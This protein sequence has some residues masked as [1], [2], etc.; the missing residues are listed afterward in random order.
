[1]S[2]STGGSQQALGWYQPG[3]SR[4]RAREPLPRS[5][6]RPGEHPLEILGFIGQVPL[7]GEVGRRDRRAEPGNLPANQVFEA[8]R[9]DRVVV[10]EVGLEGVERAGGKW[11]ADLESD[12]VRYDARRPQVA[13]HGIGRDGVVDARPGVPVQAFGSR[14]DAE[15]RSLV[16]VAR[17]AGGRLGL[18]E[19]H[20]ALVRADE[21]FPFV[22]DP[23][24]A[25]AGLAVGQR[26]H[27]AAE[28]AGGRSQRGL[29]GI[30]GQAPDEKQFA[31]HAAPGRSCA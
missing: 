8:A 11:Q 27:Q 3:Q 20:D 23:A 2:R 21:F 30:G 26:E 6:R 10:C 24:A 17:E 18:C 28:E 19:G 5:F 22:A 14:P 9:G 15:H 13:E 31:V 29:R 16:R 1:M 7:D 4:H 12:P 25:R